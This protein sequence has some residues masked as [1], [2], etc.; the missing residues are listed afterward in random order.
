MAIQVIALTAPQPAAT[1]TRPPAPDQRG[2]A[3]TKPASTRVRRQP[4][5]STDPFGR[6][7]LVLA[8]LAGGEQPIPFLEFLQETRILREDALDFLIQGVGKGMGGHHMAHHRTS[9]HP[10]P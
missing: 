5:A 10:G 9:H 7:E 6:D 1:T 4:E 8:D 3:R 2:P